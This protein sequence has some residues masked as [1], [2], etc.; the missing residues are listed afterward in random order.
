M[1]EMPVQPLFLPLLPQKCHLNLQGV[2]GMDTHAFL[3]TEHL[4]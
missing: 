1:F 2:W 4:L 3:I